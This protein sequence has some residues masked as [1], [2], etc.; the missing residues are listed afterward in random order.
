MQDILIPA[1]LTQ[2]VQ[3]LWQGKGMLF[4]SA[5]CGFGKSAV[6][7]AL[8]GSRQVCRRSGG[9]P[10]LA[11]PLP[12]G[13][14]VLVIDRIPL[15]QSPQEQSQLC[16]LLSSKGAVPS[17]LLSRGRIPS[18]LEPFHLEGRMTLVTE[19]DLR[20][21]PSDLSL[22][23]KSGGFQL[24][25]PRLNQIT[26][27]IDGY[28]L[29][30]SMLY[31][32][33]IEAE[34]AQPFL[35]EEL[36]EELHWSIYQYIDQFVFR[37]FPSDVGALLLRLSLFE[38]FTLELAQAM[39]EGS[40]SHVHGLIQALLTHTTF[41]Q[42]K[43][44]GRFQLKGQFR[45]FL[46]WKRKET[47]T[48]EEECQLYSR[49]GL[50]FEGEGNIAQSLDCYVKSKEYHRITDILAENANQN[51][52]VGHFLEME[53]YYL[54]TP[55][56]YILQSPALMCGMSMLTSLRANY[57]ESD[58][59]YDRLKAYGAGLKPN[60][61]SYREVKVKLHYLDI[62]LPQ[63][64]IDNLMDLIT[65][66][67]QFVSRRYMP[68]PAF[69]ITS[70]LPSLLNGGKDFSAWMAQDDLMYAT[71][72]KPLELML[73]REGV[74][75][76]DCGICESKF[77]Q[78]K[79]YSA[80]LMQM[81]STLSQV[82]QQGTV[83]TEFAILGLVARIQM[84]QGKADMARQSLLRLRQRLVTE[85]EC[86]FLPNL[87]ALL[88][89]ISLLQGNEQEIQQWL[90]HQA[91]ADTNGIW[92]LWRYQYLVKAEAY[93]QQG[94]YLEALLILGQLLTYTQTCGRQ[95]DQLSVHLTMAICYYRME[96]R[97]WRE[98]L[99]TGLDL[100]LKYQ[101]VRGVTRYG[102]ALLPLLKASQWQKDE[103]YLAKLIKAT[104][105]EASLYQRYLVPRT[106]VQGRLSE[107]ELQVLRLICQ[108]KSNQEIGDIMDIK[109]PT[110]KTHVS[111][112]LRKLSV[113]RRSEAKSEALRRNLV[114]GSMV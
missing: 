16:Q 53:G 101:M 69:S 97:L 37:S 93:I 14:Q 45:T 94:E 13:C 60:N 89:R 112:V 27:D 114:E 76:A 73:G 41:L 48:S 56:H 64:G 79:E 19:E 21:S 70:T 11:E 4:F 78:G 34:P 109:L 49:A 1:G 90:N 72:K 88:C 26:A 81:M 98:S 15:I 25:E 61:P 8:C 9:E 51:P 39:D 107:T 46:Q 66:A 111:N 47:L 33:L 23:L 67:F 6:A 80:Q 105:A 75:L 85:Q 32:H 3:R 84:S 71:L 100:S 35:W 20:F 96:D 104:R 63:R 68:L 5:F 92:V 7:D 36:R 50:Y 77:E 59:W 18:W 110:V 58:A 30:I 57:A 38:D 62:S 65:K 113:K 83:D 54:A 106:Q 42:Q 40:T 44:Q 24:S 22:L 2:K 102:T 95:F 74:G 103:A 52:G 17:I 91:P 31:R 87:D 82:Q 99:S 86:R 12:Q 10:D 29:A 55:E 108:D 28:P 43:S